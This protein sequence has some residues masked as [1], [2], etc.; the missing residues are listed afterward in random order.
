MDSDDEDGNYLRQVRLREKE[1][2]LREK[3]KWEFP[4]RIS[5]HHEYKVPALEFTKFICSLFALD[6]AFSMQ[7]NTLKKNL[8][9]LCHFK[10]FS[11]EVQQGT[12]PSLVLVI[13]DV[14]CGNC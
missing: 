13:P 4:H 7:A 11:A 6:P 10:E 3:R 2:E 5:S 8:L 14:I 9:T 12:E 1:R